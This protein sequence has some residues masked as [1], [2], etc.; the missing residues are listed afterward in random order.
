[1]E[2][3]RLLDPDRVWLTPNIALIATVGKGM[4][5]HVGVAARLCVSL[6]EAR[7]N[8]RVLDQGSSEMNIIVGVDEVDMDKAVRAIYDAFVDWNSAVEE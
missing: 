4:N 2:I 5:H 1:M 6:A 8:V 3:D 7:V